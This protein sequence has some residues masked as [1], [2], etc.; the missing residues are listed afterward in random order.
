MVKISDIAQSIEKLA[1][2]ELAEP[3]DNV[4]LL[5]GDKDRE[6]KTVMVMLDADINTINEAVNEGVDLIVTHHPLFIEPQKTVTDKKILTLIENKIALYSA[7]TNL[8]STRGGV[9]DALAERLGLKNVT[10][11][12]LGTLTTRMGDVETC[13]LLQFISLVKTSL[14][15]K[16]VRYTGSLTKEVTK[17]VILGGSGADLY[18]EAK[19]TGADVYLTADMKYHQAQAAAEIGMCMV[20]AGHYET[21]RCIGQYLVDYL[22]KEF[23]TLTVLKSKRNESYI[24]YE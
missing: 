15:I 21:E 17:V 4:G 23:P 7:H 2:K 24:K 19:A 10:D 14:G 5:V 8:D 18:E 13:S 1:P 12:T 16:K 20:D 6:I 9:N 11:V 3:W 22:E